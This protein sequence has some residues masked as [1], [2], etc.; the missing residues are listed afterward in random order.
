M[1][2]EAVDVDH[3]HALQ[4]NSLAQALSHANAVV[5]CENRH[6][7]LRQGMGPEGLLGV[8]YTAKQSRTSKYEAVQLAALQR[9]SPP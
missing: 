2:S 3:L 8:E 4:L 9:G 6:F 7:T 5:S 1:R